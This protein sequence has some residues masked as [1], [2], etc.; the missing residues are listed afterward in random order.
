M[1]QGTQM[2]HNGF[3]GPGLHHELAD[4]V[5]G[6]EFSSKNVIPIKKFY[7]LS[8]KFFRMFILME[9]SFEIRA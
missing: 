7:K 3:L 1:D 6:I 8:K 9:K 4:G 5:S 2:G